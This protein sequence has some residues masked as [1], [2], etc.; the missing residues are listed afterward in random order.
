MQ[1]LFAPAIS[2]MNRLRYR[3]K[4][5]VLGA[6]VSALIVVLVATLFFLL[7]DVIR[8]A[9]HELEGTKMLRPINRM[10]QQMQQHR[11]MSA[12]LLGGNEGMRDKRA[13]KEKEVTEALAAADATLS[14]ALRE[15]G[16]WKGIREDW[17]RIRD[18]G[19]NWT[20]PENV[21]RH[22]ELIDRALGFMV[23]VADSTDLT[24]DPAI[25]TYYMMETVV[26]KMPAMLERLGQT[27][28]RGT[29]VLAKKEI[30]P[31][32]KVD[33][34]STLAEMSNTLRA[35]NINLEKVGR[36]APAL[37]GTLASSGGEF[38]ADVEKLFSLVREDILGER[39]QTPSQDYFNLTT[40]VID[41]GYQ[42]MYDV[43]LPRFEELLQERIRDAR[44]KLVVNLGLVLTGMAI[45]AYLA[46]GAYF[47][48][49]NSVDVFS[50]G[51]KRLAQG[52]LAARFDLDGKDELHSAADDFNG[53]AAAFRELIGR[54]Q[55]GVQQ[56]RTA[57]GDLATSSQQICTSAGTQSDSASAMAASV[58]EMTVGV[59][60]ISRN[61]Q[62]A[63]ASSQE[64]DRV[65]AVGRRIVDDVVEE[66]RLIAGTVNQTAAAVGELGHQS[67][68]IS[69]IVETI[70]EIA[71]QTN[72][73][74]LNAAIEAARA[75]ETGRGFAVVAD[76]VRKLAERT[77]KST[78]EISEM[79]VS[80]QS[81]TQAA[82]ESMK[83]GVAR[84][85]HGVDQ[86]VS[87]G[88][89]IHR[90]QEQ[91]QQVVGAIGEISTALREQSSASNEIAQNVERI[92]QMAEENNAAAA[93]NAATAG[94]LRRL[95]ERLG[96]EVGRFRT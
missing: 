80:I 39:F 21:K 50:R 9:Q 51:A 77:G 59:D 24:L 11:G 1:A 91:S 48:V 68:R 94:E 93:A 73:L 36:F 55:N 40:A 31:Q 89:A 6:V 70:K 23:T 33:M 42:T 90:V 3:T 86:A 20:V 95:A 69:A 22:N 78:Q 87:A 30:S 65:A 85:S 4:F 12:G 72:L 58:E 15:G 49:M 66:I 53:M 32:M 82:V 37:K 96:Q 45:V 67:D 41:R 38:S 10:V 64:S 57:A 61:A 5:F 18:Q 43:L 92:A 75:G 8:T 46:A 81:R 27:R 71:D 76:E 17:Q 29:G 2:L 13:A 84:V 14:S 52:D 54:I 26:V 35:Q 34:A 19:L 74:A 44:T 60:H 88:T 83:Q 47:S 28:A 16:E 79:I 56:L 25:D 7:N 62:D 63:Q